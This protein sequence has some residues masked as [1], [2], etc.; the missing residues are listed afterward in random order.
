[1]SFRYIKVLRSR[2]FLIGVIIA[3]G[4]ISSV[5][6]GKVATITSVAAG[7]VMIYVGITLTLWIIK[8][9]VKRNKDAEI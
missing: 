7:I 4:I 5:T 2:I 6:K 3:L 1:M 8:T 9:P